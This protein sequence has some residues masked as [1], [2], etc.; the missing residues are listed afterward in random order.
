MKRVLRLGDSIRLGYQPFVA[1]ALGG[2][3]VV[4][5]PP[6]NCES[7]RVLRSKLRVWVPDRPD[8][9]HVNC[10]LHD[11]RY[12]PGAEHT[13]VDIG[14]YQENVEAILHDLEA[15]GVERIVWASTTPVNDARNDPQASRRWNEDIDRYD[16]VARTIA[17]RCGAAYDDLNGAVRSRGATDLLHEDGVHFTQPGYEFLASKVVDAVARGIIPRSPS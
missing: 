6:E 7:S 9:V 16:L 1:A 13:N 5:G 14:E 2:R 10:G 8:I 3:A 17:E 15:L 12:D 11:V 4:D